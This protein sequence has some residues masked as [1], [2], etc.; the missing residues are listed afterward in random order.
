MKRG[1]ALRARPKPPPDPETVEAMAAFKR[2]IRGLVCVVCG[3]KENQAYR[4][5]GYGHQAHHGIR[6]QVLDR[7]HL[8][9][10]DTRLA[11]C[12]C[13]EPCHRRITSTKRRLRRRELP[14]GL[15]EFVQEYGLERQLEIE[16]GG[17]S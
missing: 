11:V 16:L 1:K 6:Q 9:L 17:R 8:P 10:W 15:L 12:V 14:T 2:S 13:T 5:T 3:R 7:L 4:E